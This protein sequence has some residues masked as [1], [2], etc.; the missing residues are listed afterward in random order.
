MKKKKKMENNE[1]QKNGL[2]ATE[3]HCANMGKDEYYCSASVASRLGCVFGLEFYFYSSYC[4][5]AVRCTPFN[6]IWYEYVTAIT[7]KHN[8]LRATSPWKSQEMIFFFFFA[9]ILIN[10]WDKY[11]IKSRMK[12]TN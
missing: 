5:I 7:H 12:G 8:I 2:R 3:K 6:P 1:Q 9:N 11:E 4:Q 10:L